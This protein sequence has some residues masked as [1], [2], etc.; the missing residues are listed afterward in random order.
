MPD[1]P[2]INPNIIPTNADLAQRLQNILRTSGA[3]GP[4][5]VNYPQLGGLTQTPITSTGPQSL[6][7]V[8]QLYNQGAISLEQA[9]QYE[10]LF[11]NG[12]SSMED[13][14]QINPDGSLVA[15]RDQMNQ[16]GAGRN[17]NGLPLMNFAGSDLTT[18]LFALGA[19]I[20]A[21]RGTQGRGLGIIS[22][23]GAAGLGIARGIASGIGYQR[24]NQYVDQ[25]NNDLMNDQR[26]TPNPQYNASNYLG[27]TPTGE[28]GGLFMQQ[29]GFIDGGPDKSEMDRLRMQDMEASR[30]N[31]ATLGLEGTVLV[32][33]PQ[34]LALFE[35]QL[36]ASLANKRLW[37][38]P[39]RSGS[40][41][42]DVNY[43]NG[44]T[45]SSTPPPPMN[46]NANTPI[47]GTQRFVISAQGA[48]T[49]GGKQGA[50][51]IPYKSREELDQLNR[52][53]RNIKSYEDY[54]NSELYKIYGDA[55][56]KNPGGM[57]FEKGGEYNGKKI[58]D[59]VTFKHGGKMYSGTIKKIENGQIYI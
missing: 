58:G 18:E 1:F 33:D 49:V 54:R 9:N 39:D 30:I 44:P 19:N 34:E 4:I 8:D 57:A 3:Q 29:G 37:V 15:S 25:Y 48:N 40:Y 2:Y 22:T 36:G 12:Q 53:F 59:K 17:A 5:N 43:G 38:T 35:S 42:V 26:Y 14:A 55:P 7:E 31:G 21:P 52:Q 41:V 6:E 45:T 11:A 16:Y 20:G 47:S 27:G 56:L 51:Y 28:Y 32:T 13:N 10:L 50:L 24:R 46:T 23:A